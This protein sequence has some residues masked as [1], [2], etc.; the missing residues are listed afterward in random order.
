[1]G[2][3]LGST[4]LLGKEGIAWGRILCALLSEKGVV[5]AVW[6]RILSL[7]LKAIQFCPH[8]IH[9]VLKELPIALFKLIV[10]N[11]LKCL[12]ML[13][14]ELLFRNLSKFMSKNFIEIRFSKVQK[15]VSLPICL[16]AWEASVYLF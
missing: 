11:L 15:I 9:S 7:L 8:S 2:A 16:P 13:V 5:A 10:R 6:D 12:S 1:M 14:P 4:T 3:F